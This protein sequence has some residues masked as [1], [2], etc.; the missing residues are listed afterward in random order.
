MPGS[1]LKENKE[2]DKYHKIDE[3]QGDSKKMWRVINE[4]RGKRRKQIKPSFLINNERIICRRIIAHEFNNYFVSIASNL[5]KA[6]D[7]NSETNII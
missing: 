7:D 4:V 1:V 2:Y 3:C 6:Y 5:N